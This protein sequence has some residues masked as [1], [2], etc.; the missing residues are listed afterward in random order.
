M[1]RLRPRCSRKKFDRMSELRIYFQRLGL[2]FKKKK[3]GEKN[4]V[5]LW[6]NQ[7]HKADGWWEEVEVSREIQ[8]SWVSTL[9]RAGQ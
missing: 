9:G 6:I 4:Q 1:E 7:H 2:Y 8:L 3:K 5:R